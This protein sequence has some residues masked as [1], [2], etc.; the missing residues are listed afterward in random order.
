MS[1]MVKLYYS[2]SSF[3]LEALIKPFSLNNIN[4]KLF[5]F[6]FYCN[7]SLSLSSIHIL[8]LQLVTHIIIFSNCGFSVFAFENYL[9]IFPMTKDKV[10]KKKEMLQNCVRDFVFYIKKNV[11]VFVLNCKMELQWQHIKAHLIQNEIIIL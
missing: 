6:Y 1:Y 4:R 2:F 5:N 3:A 9:K 8:L 7:G 11:W 10:T